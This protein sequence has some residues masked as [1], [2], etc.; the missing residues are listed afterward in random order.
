VELTGEYGKIRR[1]WCYGEE[2]FRRELLWQ[3]ARQLGEHHYGAER[4]ETAEAK[5]ERIVAEG[6]EKAGWEEADVGR[7]AKGDPVK[8]GLAARLRQETTM[9]LKW[10]CERLKMGAWQSLNQ[11][12]Y[13]SRKCSKISK[14]DNVR[15]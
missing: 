8:T 10:I 1:G 5:A 6:L 14:S 4:Q 3:A 11:R 9:T 7:F 2:A 13:E 12:L 15:N